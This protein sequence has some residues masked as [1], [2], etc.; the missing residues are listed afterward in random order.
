MKPLNVN[1]SISITLV[2]V[3]TSEKSSID[4]LSQA[5]LENPTQQNLNDLRDGI[6]M[7]SDATY[8]TNSNDILNQYMIDIQYEANYRSE[9]NGRS[10]L[11]TEEQFNLLST[12]PSRHYAGG[13]IYID[14][15]RPGTENY[16]Y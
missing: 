2:K 13:L 1:V 7:F 3:N 16:Y 11:L 9:N 8:I 4:R 12:D 5:Y 14:T 15:T 10:P 6:D